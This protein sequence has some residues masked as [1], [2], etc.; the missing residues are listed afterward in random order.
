MV[1]IAIC[2]AGTATMFAQETG[3]VGRK[4]YV[5]FGGGANIIGNVFGGGG[6]GLGYYINP[7]SLLSADIS[8][9]SYTEKEL[10]NFQIYKTT[11]GR[12]EY[13]KDGS[14]NYD[15]SAAS[16]LLSWS[17][18]VDLTDKFQWRIGP[19][20]GSLSI[21][22]ADSYS[23]T[24]IGGVKIDGIPESQSLSQEAFAYGINTGVTWNFSKNQR[25][26]LDLGYKLYGNTGIKFEER[27]L[28]VLG[29]SF[30]VEEKEFSK[31]GNKISLTVGWRF[32]KTN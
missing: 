30:T 24:E 29:R 20:I 28:N 17:Y 21:S 16:F 12:Q 3:V 23:P 25:W 13:Y 8:F 6:I 26:F 32:G 15:Y 14:V 9:G 27:R 5:S 22:G 2:L 4:W 31:I 7:K 18:I 1:A 11:N 10:G 19:S